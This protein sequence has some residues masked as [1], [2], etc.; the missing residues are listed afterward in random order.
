MPV[1]VA[2]SFASTPAPTS[3]KS[4]EPAD[5]AISPNSSADSAIEVHQPKTVGRTSRIARPPGPDSSRSRGALRARSG[6]MPTQASRAPAS[7]TA[8]AA[9]AAVKAAIGSRASGRGASK[10]R[11]YS[12]Q[13][14]GD[15]QISACSPTPASAIIRTA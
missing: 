11:S 3:R 10:G 9:S 7:R 5:L 6:R 8:T 1:P 14:S 15:A 13:P 2:P 12:T 4:C